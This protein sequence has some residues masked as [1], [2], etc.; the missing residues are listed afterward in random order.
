MKYKHKIAGV[1]L[2]LSTLSLVGFLGFFEGKN[3]AK[4]EGERISVEEFQTR[5]KSYPPQFAS[6]L[7]EKNNK[8]KIL[9]QMIDEKILIVAAK[10]E[11]YSKS[12]DY[13]NQIDAA[14]NQLLLSMYVKDKIEKKV[15]VTDEDVRLFYQNNPK[16]FQE[17]E[18]RRARHIL[19]KTEAEAMDVLRKLRAGMDFVT[20]AKQKSV[21]ATAANGG[22]LG[23]FTRGQLVPEFEQAV[24]ALQ[25]GK[26]SDIVKTQF[27]YHVI[28]VE[29]MSI[30]PRLEYEAVKNQVKEA[31]VAEKRRTVITK[32]IATLKKQ[33]K[34]KKDISNI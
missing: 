34:I 23:W 22:D 1:V 4:V 15:V 16:Q 25:R 29:D 11:G 28:R 9:D 10:K 21:D 6:A 31:L 13:T 20:L 14:K 33:Y 12:K 3:V 17:V 24:F 5:L 30:R 8:V 19:V 32:T 26:V 2:A 27:G 7:T 18:Q